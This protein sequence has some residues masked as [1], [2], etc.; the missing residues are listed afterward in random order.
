MAYSL[1]AARQYWRFP[2]SKA[3]GKK[4]TAEYCRESDAFIKDLIER[5]TRIPRKPGLHGGWRN[6]AYGR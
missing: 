2:P 3:C 5:E 1:D 6:A 4:D